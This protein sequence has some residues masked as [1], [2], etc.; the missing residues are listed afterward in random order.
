MKAGAA[1]ASASGQSKDSRAVRGP[2]SRPLGRPRQVIVD[3]AQALAGTDAPL[4]PIAFFG[5]HRNQLSPGSLAGCELSWP[6]AVP[7][8][9]RAPCE[10]GPGF[11]RPRNFSTARVSL[12]TFPL[13]STKLP[14][15]LPR[16]AHRRVRSGRFQAMRFPGR[17]RPQA[18]STGRSF[19]APSLSAGWDGSPCLHR[20]SRCCLPEILARDFP[21]GRRASR[22]ANCR[23]PCPSGGP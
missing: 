16:R 21:G 17:I 9:P 2:S 5:V 11:L 8:A 6:H 1:T 22:S 20:G 18:G 12:S 19:G 14:G 10:R 13:S 15:S 23:R 3:E 7:R 4:F